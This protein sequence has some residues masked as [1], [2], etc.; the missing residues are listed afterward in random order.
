MASNVR[1]SRV[2]I[3]LAALPL[4]LL[5][6]LSC[7]RPGEVKL[8][9]VNPAFREYVEAFTS[10]VVSTHA[11]V[12]VRLNQPYVDSSAVGVPVTTGLLSVD[13]SVEGVLV[14]SDTR[15]LEFRP[16]KPLEQD[17]LFTAQ[18]FISKLITVPDSL[19]TMTFQFRTMK[20]DFDVRIDH[21]WAENMSDVNRESIL[22]T[23]T[24]ADVASDSAVELMLKATQ[25]GKP[26]SVAWQHDGAHN[27]HNYR[28]EGVVR[29]PA[30]SVVKLDFDGKPI[31]SET[32][33][34]LAPEVAPTGTFGFTGWQN[35]AGEDPCFVLT[36]T[37]PLKSGQ[38]PEGMVH[39]GKVQGLRV[40][41][42][43]NELLVYPPPESENEFTLTV[44]PFLKNYDGKELGQRIQLKLNPSGNKPAV[45]FA[46]TGAVMPPSAGMLLPFEAVNLRA[47]DVKVTRIFQDNIL[48]F[49]QTNDLATSFDLARVGKV[50]LRKTMPLNGSAD[51]GRWNRYSIDMST[52]I[53]ADPGA[54][55]TVTLSFSKDYSAYPC[56]S[57]S[58]SPQHDMVTFRAIDEGDQV[59]WGY[60]S[61]YD[62]DWAAYGGWNSYR[63]QERN[64]PCKNSYYFNKSVSRNV[65][66]SNLGLIAKGSGRE[67]AVFVTDLVSAKPVKDARVRLLSYQQQP[68]AEGTTD[69]DGMVRLT[70]NSVPAFVVAER[71][72]EK[73][74]LRLHD[75]SSVSL[76]MFDVGGEPVQKGL[77]GF[78]YG[79]RGVWRPGDSIFLT[80]ML[81]DK[82]AKLPA[83][84]PVS[85]ALTDPS[86]QLATRLVN[87]SP[88]NG[89][90]VFR[91]ATSAGAPTGNWLATVRAG[92]ALFTR[93]L[94]IETVKP[95]RLKINL[96]FG[97]AELRVNQPSPIT[98]QAA[99][100]TGAPAGSLKAQV[101]LTLTRAA[102]AFAKYPG[103]HFE[104]PTA[105]FAA[106]N[107]TVFDGKL[108]A[109]GSAVISPVIHVVNVAPGMLNASFETKVFEEGG[110]FS[111]DRFTI[112]YSPFATY[113]G[114]KMPG[115]RG[116][117]STDREYEVQLLNVDADG[118]PAPPG[119]LNVEVFKL[120]WR[121]WWDDSENN[122]AD[123]VS[124][125][126]LAPVDQQKVTTAGG[127]GSYRFS[128][129]R[130][131]WGR[132]LVRVTD[133]RSGHAAAKVVYVDWPDYYRMPGGEKQAASMLTLTTDKPK[134]AVGDRVKVTIPTTPDGR[135]LLTIE[136]GSGVI[137]ESWTPTKKGTTEITFRATEAMAPNCYAYV[138]LI[139]PHA[140][141]L[142]DLPIRL[143][144]V[145]PV[146]VENPA[147]HL[148]PV[149]GLKGKLTPMQPATVTVKEAA[150][151]PMTY[152]LAIVDEGLLDLTR[153]KTPDPWSVFYAREALG[154]KT[155]DLY[156]QVMGAFSGDLQRILSIG[157][158][159]DLLRRS[160]LK[161]NR[162]KPM[163][164]FFGPYRLKAGETGITTF[165]MPEYIG[166]VRIMAIAGNDGAYG[167]GELTAPVKK[168]LMVQGT[169]PRV[170]GPG[171]TVTLPVSVFAMEPSVRNATVTLETNDLFDVEGGKSRS[172]A[173]S[174]TGD[175]LVTFTLKVREVTGIGRVTLRAASGNERAESTIEIDVRNPGL[176]V[177]DV[178]DKEL[179]AG[180]SQTFT[181]P[182]RGMKGTNSGVVELSSMPPFNLEKWLSFLIRYP[183]GCV[184][185]TT[186]SVFPQL[187]LAGLA[188]MGKGDGTATEANIRAGIRRL[189]SFQNP[190]GG[191][192][193]W[194]GSPYD[195]DWGTSYAGHFMLEAEKKGFTL[196]SG[197]IQAWKVYQ[198]EKA[199]S[200][201]Y[202]VSWANDDLAQAYRLYTL[203]LAR[204]PE[205]GAMNKLAEKKDL[206][207]QARWQLAGAYALAGKPEAARRLINGV[208]A[209]IRPYR[210]L[211]QTYGSDLR[212]KAMI[213]QV[214]TLLNMRTEAA[215]LAREMAA[216]LC[217]N[218]WYDTQ[219]S[220]FCL[221]ALSGFYGK[222]SRR[223]IE[224][225]FAVDNNPATVVSTAKPVYL[226]NFDPTPG[227]RQSVKIVNK[228]K[229]PLFARVLVRGIPVTGD[230]SSASNGLKMTVSYTA[231]GGGVVN[232]ATLAQGTTFM[233]EVKIT[234]TGNRGPLP[235]L[236]L[237]QVFPPGWEIGNS[238]MSEATAA[239]TRASAFS[240]Q[241]VRDDRLITYFDL[242]TGETK[243]F[244]ALLTA[245]Y[246]GR[247]RMPPVQCEAMYDNTFNA[248]VPGR[249]VRVVK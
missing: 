115:E 134:Y 183:Y 52:L 206:S 121:W 170:M 209:I 237:V 198:R 120:E 3:P 175:R 62:D 92:G 73:G 135:A 218:G 85:L 146:L 24:T 212:D 125:S 160:S 1:F 29:G 127:R 45:R 104:N 152:T 113:A 11:T 20:Q 139:Q 23:L 200:W 231:T 100:L 78:L 75:G 102:T 248:R 166:S 25:A 216:Q 76:S 50:I 64:D 103:F 147:T 229:G 84:Y 90:Y 133:I 16:G 88:L 149:I 15:T 238:R 246:L 30:A 168:A 159:K 19:K 110:D 124:T 213:L 97:K 31:G 81:E 122:S 178:Y 36:F 176:P 138:T 47:V 14:W 35:S 91:L 61:G 205:A 105:S 158:D 165:T 27:T 46:G 34:M 221:I 161:A 87:S 174:G 40:T 228:G 167:S 60:Y 51:Y 207:P 99:W 187:Y 150:G 215:P 210:E 123:F 196:P 49:L 43:N 151:K 243:T 173:F 184:E 157:G 17:R 222:E 116:T 7:H 72:G 59:P 21:H 162:F 142:N 227:A 71:S 82:T 182:V 119:T 41:I 140:Q 202:N 164:R 171:E 177:T 10:G 9:R 214:M 63:W 236:A 217:R 4:F 224:A 189:K 131:E 67:F 65:F 244:R 111:I 80:F 186:S 199:L 42:R 79:D 208:S 245:T 48:Q 172:V 144:G 55:Y 194:P 192:A 54:I 117:L 83:N 93:S 96:N 153:F 57:S 193:Y 180:G 240:Y 44:E 137:Q 154:V 2:A 112:P 197:F 220:A 95:N 247:F 226:G 66:A 6:T 37:D 132:Y 74:Y 101:G 18:F 143:Y 242:G 118:N 241:D 32:T 129:A 108:N 107:A 26:L 53:K 191:L 13:P 233:A 190:G 94:K 188:E 5:L 155:W 28:V 169:L 8:A 239:L 219:T 249:W 22:G 225:T 145:L 106:E 181:F 211:S 114:L 234:N 130:E 203:A 89:F 141:A 185:Q 68:L 12:R 223:G 58:V 148:K 195:D 77:K 69:A 98:L 163:V 70:G 235:N 232:P 179:P 109:D 38:D 204:A 126:H 230:S 56:N 86:G 128:V 201:P 33:H 136:N 156:D 39:I